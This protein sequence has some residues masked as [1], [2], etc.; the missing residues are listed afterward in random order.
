MAMHLKWKCEQGAAFAATLVL[1]A[2][3][4]RIA[5][6]AE[7]GG[8]SYMQGTYGDFGAAIAPPSYL[9][10]DVILYDASIGARPVNGGLDPGFDQDLWM[11]RLTL[12]GYSKAEDSWG[13]RDSAWS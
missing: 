4:P 2:G 8:S 10:N 12:G 13:A 7:G 3:L 5:A 6:A 11:D 9:R 1:A